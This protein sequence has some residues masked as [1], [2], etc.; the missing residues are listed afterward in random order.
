MWY[1][2]RPDAELVWTDKIVK[3]R[4]KRYYSILKKKKYARY[5]I[6]K[7]FPV[8]FESSA[9]L[10]TLWDLHRFAQ[11]KFKDFVN[12]VDNRK[13]D[14]NALDTPETSYLDLKIEIAKRLLSSCIF[15]EWRCKVNRLDGKRGVCGVGKIAH[16][17]SAFLH[18]GEE[19]PLVPS[20]TIFF[21]GC[22]FKCVYCQNYDISQHPNLGEEVTPKLLAR[23]A[24]GLATDG[25][26]NINYVGGDPIP[27]THIILE[28]LK[29]QTKNVP[30]LW[31]S[32]LYNSTES[33]LLLLDIIDIW[34][35]DFKY[36]N[37][38]CALRL[39]KIPNYFEVIS[40]NH[41]MIADFGGETIIRHLVLPSHIECCSIPVLKWISKNFPNALVN[42]MKQYR[43]M[44]KAFDEQYSEIQRHP[45]KDEM[46]KVYDFA[47]EVG[48][49]WRPVS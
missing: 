9:N 7:K 33:L 17:S 13:I 44:Y 6:A 42:I 15:C 5:L 8:E 34:L 49:V 3:E 20:G 18:M 21:S 48:L 38:R 30:Q 37:S 19:S 10:E 11:G 32:D 24:D 22:P 39:S 41:K 16:V 47:D 28:S 23:I 12:R 14:L 27:N 45:S 43:P 29:Y 35:P 4:L 25:A 2:I 46:N 31:N 1:L 36:G 40:R 26:R